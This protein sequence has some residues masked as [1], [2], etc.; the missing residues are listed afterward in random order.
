MNDF[1]TKFFRN[2][3]AIQ[4]DCV[5]ICMA[6]HKTADKETENMLYDV[7]YEVITGIM[8]MIDGYSSFSEDK[9]DIIN[10]LTNEC[11]KENPFIELHD[12]TEEFLKY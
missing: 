12:Y 11:L 3:A 1:Q 4:E 9:H 10:K 8:E 7:T 6:K 2:L 5:Q